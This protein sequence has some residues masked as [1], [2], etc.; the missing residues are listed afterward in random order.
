MFNN[1]IGQLFGK[2]DNNSDDKKKKRNKKV[3]LTLKYI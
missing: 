3:K 1:P 2:S